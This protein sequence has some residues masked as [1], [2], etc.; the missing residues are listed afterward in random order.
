M[1]P[2]M[3]PHLSVVKRIPRYVKGTNIYGLWFHVQIDE[4]QKE[5]IGYSNSYQFGDK[6]YRRN[7][8][9]YLFELQGA[10]ISWCSKKQQVTTL[11][12][13]ETEYIV[14]SYAACQAIW[15]D[16]LLK[17][18]NCEVNNAIFLAESLYHLVVVLTL[19]QYKFNFYY[20]FSI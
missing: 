3:K 13:C 18:L 10:S 9:G 12:S 1:T 19:A 17:E 16:S 14:S 11:S 6:I 4:K 5:F 20:S 15:L 8:F 2:S 7:T